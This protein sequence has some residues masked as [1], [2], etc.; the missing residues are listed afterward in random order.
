MWVIIAW[1]CMSVL[2][3]ILAWPS[4]IPYLLDIA[5]NEATTMGTVTGTDCGNHN[6]VNYSFDVN[7]R[8]FEGH[9]L[10]KGDLCQRIVA[11]SPMMIHYSAKSP[12]HN[13]PF[14]PVAALWNEVISFLWFCLLA[15]PLMVWVV[16]R[17]RRRRAWDGRLY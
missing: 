8:S 13:V 12:E 11:G 7:G 4:S 5:Q 9:K 10:A 15:P 3:G 6:G 16:R 1:A 17:R 2:F 14:D